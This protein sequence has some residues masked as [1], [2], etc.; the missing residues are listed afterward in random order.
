MFILTFDDFCFFWL[1]CPNLPLDPMHKGLGTSIHLICLL[2]HTNLWN[3]HWSLGN[4]VGVL[5]RFIVNWLWEGRG[6]AS[7]MINT[8]A[9]L[10][11]SMYDGKVG[12]TSQCIRHAKCF[13]VTYR[14]HSWAKVIIHYRH[15]IAV[16][17]SS[18][19][20]TPEMPANYW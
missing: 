15:R 7:T 9:H 8:L 20:G 2:V 5:F 12:V 4:F 10:E 11:F 19:Q 6:S 3:L 1:L 13:F 18:P 17:P 14:A 16:S